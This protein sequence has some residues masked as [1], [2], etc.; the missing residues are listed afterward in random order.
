M[1]QDLAASVERSIG[2]LSSQVGDLTAAVSLPVVRP[3]TEQAERL[4]KV[5]TKLATVEDTLAKM[6]ERSEDNSKK[7]DAAEAVFGQALCWQISSCSL[8]IPLTSSLTST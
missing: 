8:S 6:E 3:D 2:G 5:E 1:S 4:R 7:L